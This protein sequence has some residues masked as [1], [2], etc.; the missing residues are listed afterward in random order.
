MRQE[1]RALTGLRGVAA[2]LVAFYHL[3]RTTPPILG[4]VVSHFYLGVD[5]FFVLSGFV[6]ALTYRDRFT[7]HP[8]G[9]ALLAFLAARIARIYPLYVATTL[10]M[11]GLLAL[12]A[13]A[14]LEGSAGLLPNM[15]MIQTWGNG[16]SINPPSWSISTE[17]AA[18]LAFP[19]LLAVTHRA[20]IV[21]YVAGGAAALTL[22]AIAAPWPTPP[23]MVGPL[24]LYR[25]DDLRPVARCLAEFSLGLLAHRAWL[26]PEIARIATA[27]WTAPVVGGVLIVLLAV[28]PADLL[29][30]ALLPI[31]VVSLT[32]E[33]SAP[34]R[35]LASP[36]PHQL[37]VLSYAIYL[38]HYMLLPV[39]AWLDAWTTLPAMV[40]TYGGLIALAGVAH[41]LIE[42]PARRG[43]RGLLS[44]GK[45]GS[46]GQGP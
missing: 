16:W 13:A 26:V 32:A 8:L 41:R 27:R 46:A 6:M 29:I 7:G 15:L 1:L 25:P 20:R 23:P 5:L 14:P 36:L 30:V 3:D 2:L 31:L 12:G 43:I 17:W 11:A 19:A 33:T 45:Q 37:G 28:P 34:A 22:M 40:I 35:L 10:A 44:A 21:A 24:D 42:R 18:Y 39:R 38:L 4:G 9:R